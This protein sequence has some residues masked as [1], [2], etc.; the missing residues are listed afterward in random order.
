[1]EFRMLTNPSTGKELHTTKTLRM[2]QIKRMRIAHKRQFTLDK[3][4]TFKTTWPVTCSSKSFDEQLLLIGGDDRFA[5][6]CVQ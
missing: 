6:N 5:N 1:M 4:C 2:R 3:S